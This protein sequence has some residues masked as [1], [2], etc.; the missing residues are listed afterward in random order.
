MVQHTQIIK[1]IHCINRINK[2]HMIISIDTE[3]EFNK[4]QYPF[5]IKVLNKLGIKGS[6]L[7]ILKAIQDQ[8]IAT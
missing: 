2:N 3:N 6:C 1:V 7:N 8:Q 5:M 4:I